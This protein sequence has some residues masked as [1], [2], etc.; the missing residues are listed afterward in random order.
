[1]EKEKTELKPFQFLLYPKK[2][3]GKNY[4]NKEHIKHKWLFLVSPKE[5]VDDIKKYFDICNSFSNNVLFLNGNKEFET[6]M[7]KNDDDIRRWIQFSSQDGGKVSLYPEILKDIG[8]VCCN[9]TSKEIGVHLDEFRK[10]V[11]KDSELSVTQK[12]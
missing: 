10:R 6:I 2:A 12:R 8:A 5:F 7:G 1:M 9:M 4:W 11:I 3:K